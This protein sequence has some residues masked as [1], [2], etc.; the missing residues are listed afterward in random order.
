MELAELDDNQSHKKDHHYGQKETVEL[1]PSVLP[2]FVCSSTFVRAERPCLRHRNATDFTV[3]MTRNIL[4]GRSFHDQSPF[5][6]YRRPILF[7][8]DCAF[9]R[10]GRT[11][12]N[13]SRDT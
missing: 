3:S 12:N 7:S 4:E 11:E 10:F 2:F 8:K 5:G 6:N 13:S 1:L 9:N